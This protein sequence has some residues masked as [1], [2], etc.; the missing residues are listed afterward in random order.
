MSAGMSLAGASAA[1]AKTAPAASQ[2]KIHFRMMDWQGQDAYT[3]AYNNMIRAYEKLHPNISITQVFVPQGTG[4][5]SL[6]QTG[7]LAGSAPSLVELQQPNY[8]TFYNDGYLVNL[9][10]YMV[11]PTPYSHGTPWINT[12]LGGPT[13]FQSIQEGNQA[14]AINVV[15][16]DGDGNG[17][18]S[19]L[20][21]YVNLNILH[22]SGIKNV[23]TTYTQF[24][25]DCAKI[26]KAGYTPIVADNNRWLAWIWYTLGAQMGNGYAAKFFPKKYAVPLLAPDEWAVAILDGKINAKD[27]L[28]M[29]MA[30][31]AKSLVPYFQSGWVGTTISEG[32]TLWMA[33]GGAF[34][35]TGSWNYGWYK[36]NVKGFKFKV[37]GWPV[38]VLPKTASPY[39]DQAWVKS[40]GQITSGWSVNAKLLKDPA[41]L[42]AVINFL[43]YA[44]SRSA[45]RAFSPAAN[46]FPEVSGVPIP[47]AYKPFVLPNTADTLAAPASTASPNAPPLMQNTTTMAAL[48]QEY[49]SGQISLHHFMTTMVS[50]DMPYLRTE[51]E[52][53]I[54]NAKTGLPAQIKAD[55]ATLQQDEREHAAKVVIQSA[56]QALNLAQLRLQF[57]DRYALPYMKG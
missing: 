43:Q 42:R 50:D 45:Q 24:L 17:P 47:S 28:D 35:M 39:A 18:A 4:Y 2:A 11:R 29:S 3:T 32:K 23:P 56:Q 38:Y 55:M 48:S 13:G 21:F 54:F 7:Y 5:E 51:F 25:A 20:G 22:K 14:G 1:L 19:W 30:K 33:G 31:I 41:K 34:R 44:T 57:Y 12:F 15:P 27:P 40:G 49:L 46:S 16:V 8:E 37:L 52:N 26:K 53:T 10:S 9:N 6:L 36:Q